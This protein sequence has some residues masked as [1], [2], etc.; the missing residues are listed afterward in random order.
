VEASPTRIRF[1]TNGDEHL[2]APIV[3]NNISVLPL[4]KNVE[5]TAVA[6]VGEPLSQLPLGETAEVLNIS[7]NCRGAERR[8]FMD[9]GILPGIAITAEMQ[10]P[11]GEPT[12]YRIRDAIIA[13]RQSQASHIRIKK[14]TNK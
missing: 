2:L 12:A 3:A 7:P 10:S 8:R 13:L 1:W 6:I 9:L 14:G 4:Q 5:E 11:S